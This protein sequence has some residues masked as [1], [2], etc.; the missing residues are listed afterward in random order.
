MA[1]GCVDGD[2]HCSSDILPRAQF[3]A[4]D[5]RVCAGAR[6][7]VRPVVLGGAAPGV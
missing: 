5:V 6:M 3:G 4:E 1:T 7:R 2:Q